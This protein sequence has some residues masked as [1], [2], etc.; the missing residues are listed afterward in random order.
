MLNFD[1]CEAVAHTT[2]TIA[3]RNAD[4]VNIGGTNYL[5]TTSIQSTDLQ[6]NIPFTLTYTDL[7]GNSLSRSSTPNGSAVTFDI[8]PPTLAISMAQTALISGSTTTVTFTFSEPVVGFTNT[9]ITKVDGGTLSPVI[10]LDGGIVWT[11]VLTPSVLATSTLNSVVVAMSSLT[12]RAGNT[13][14]QVVTSPNYTVSPL[15]VVIVPPTPPVS[16]VV[17][18]AKGKGFLMTISTDKIKRN[19][20]VDTTTRD[21]S[22]EKEDN[23]KD[24]DES[25]C[26]KKDLR[27]GD[28]DEEV[29]ELQKRLK[30]EGLLKSEVTGYFGT[31]TKEALRTWQIKNNLEATGEVLGVSVFTFQKDLYMG[32]QDNTVSEVKELQKRL[33]AEGLLNFEPTGYFGKI[34]KKALI[35]WQIKNNLTAKG[36]LSPMSRELLNKGGERNG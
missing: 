11:A 12:D 22:K 9:S 25:Y 35:E 13:S 17:T 32:S 1:T 4:I 28:K 23:S 24:I 3:G 20:K 2:S 15:P 18:C 34:T 5:A 21:R 14:T 16:P 29:K 33:I 8:T 7:A 27:P 30:K 10:S 31:L 19:T 26:F 6:G 36:Y